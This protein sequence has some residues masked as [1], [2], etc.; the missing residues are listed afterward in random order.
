MRNKALTYKA[1]YGLSDETRLKIF[2]K[3]IEYSADCFLGDEPIVSQN[4]AKHLQTSFGLAKST[5]SHHI[6]ILKECGLI[7]EVQKKKSAYLFA[8]FVKLKELT[9]SINNDILVYAD[10]AE[11]IKIG[12]IFLKHSIALIDGLVDYLHIYDYRGLRIT[13]DNTGNP[14]LYFKINGYI[15]PLY[16][17]VTDSKIEISC[18]KRNSD[19]IRSEIE[20][21]IGIISKTY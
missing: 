8:N 16:M 19:K 17:T 3:I 11:Y 15:E 7:M 13:K 20:K 4:T 5:I 10:N 18:I 12:E 6:K 2:M 1:M 9:A 14:K 21:L